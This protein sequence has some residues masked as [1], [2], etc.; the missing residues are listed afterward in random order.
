MRKYIIAAAILILFSIHGIFAA[1]E[2]T[3][4]EELISFKATLYSGQEKMP[5]EGLLTLEGAAYDTNALKGRYALV[6]LGASWCPY[7][8]REKASLQ[9]LYKGYTNE[10]FTVLS[11]FVGGEDTETAQR[12][13]AENGYN[14]PAAVAPAD[15]LY[16][17][18]APRLPTSYVIDMEGNILARINGSKEWDSAQ[19][20]RVLDYLTGQ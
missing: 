13:M 4:Q 10:K 9:R 19:A 18:H 14:F 3:M 8:G 20:L 12:Y 5:L 15:Q 2:E 1:E 17:A 11:V 6:N 16:E 7:C